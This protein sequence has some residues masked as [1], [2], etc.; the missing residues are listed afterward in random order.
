MRCGLTAV[1]SYRIR[2]DCNRDGLHESIDPAGLDEH[3]DFRLEP[4]FHTVVKLRVAVA[5]R[6]VRPGVIAAKRCLD[7]RVA[8]AHDQYMTPKVLVWIIEVMADVRK[9]FAQNT[10]CSRR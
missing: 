6:D 9:L 7:G 2:G 1:R 4:V 5:D 3:L 8:P 10:E